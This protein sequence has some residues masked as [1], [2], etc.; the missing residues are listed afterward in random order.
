MTFIFS[1]KCQSK[2]RIIIPENI[3]DKFDIKPGELLIIMGNK[4]DK[5]QESITDFFNEY[6]KEAILG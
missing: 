3:R 5:V 2:G 6:F 1:G 4:Y